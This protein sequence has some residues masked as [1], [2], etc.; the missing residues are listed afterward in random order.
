MAK[1]LSFKCLEQSSVKPA[2]GKFPYITEKKHQK[3]IA[4]YDEPFISNVL[5]KFGKSAD[6]KLKN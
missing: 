1:H 2:K 3:F 6:W 5:P 4:K